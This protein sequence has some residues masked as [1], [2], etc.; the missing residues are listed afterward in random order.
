MKRVLIPALIAAAAFL[1]TTAFSGVTIDIG[2]S[3]NVPTGDFGDLVDPGLGI[4]ADAFVGLPMLPFEVGGRIGY[5]SFDAT[6][7]FA[8]G[9][10]DVVEIVPSIRYVF[11]PPLS[12]VKVFGQ[13]GVGAYM[14]DQKLEAVK[15]MVSSLP[16][17]E[18]DGTDFGIS[19]GAGVRA[20]LGPLTGITAMPIYNIIFTEDENT[21]YLSLNVALTF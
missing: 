15:S 13:F 18:D 12:P 21:T 11:G 4:G 5:S 16:D 7:D 2:P 10:Q 14:W 19:I 20:K 3:Y 8:G 6:D 9:E 1:S 17:I